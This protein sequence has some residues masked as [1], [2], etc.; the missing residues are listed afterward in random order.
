ML[1]STADDFRL[2]GTFKDR[3][4]MLDAI[5]ALTSDVSQQI[6]FDQVLNI[7]TP[8]TFLVQ[9]FLVHIA[10]LDTPPI[11]VSSPPANPVGHSKHWHLDLL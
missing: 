8:D 1:I 5:A 3:N 2:S 4:H 6:M 11:D 7:S 9:R 10:N